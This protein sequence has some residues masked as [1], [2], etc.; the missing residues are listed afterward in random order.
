[1]TTPKTTVHPPRGWNRWLWRLPIWLYRAHL[2]WLLTNRFLLL[3]HT[4]RRS[5][6]PRQAVIEVVKYD[7]AGGVYYVASGFGPASDWYQNLLATPQAR[8][9]SGFRSVTVTARMLSN[10]EGELILA[11]Y[12]RRHPA[13]IRALAKLIGYEIEK[14]TETYTEFAKVVPIVALKVSVPAV[15]R[16]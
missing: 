5:G 2:G 12:A 15:A 14:N 7:Q 16:A 6:Q 1:M 9:Q 13:A 11:D 4:G 10:E 3:E 8:I